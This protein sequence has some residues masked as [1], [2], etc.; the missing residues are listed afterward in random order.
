V[1]VQVLPTGPDAR[2]DA[3]AY[4]LLSAAFAAREELVLTTPYF[5][6]GE[7]MLAALA[8]AAAR[9]AQV[10]LIVPARVD[11]RL[12]EYA[13]RAFQADLIRAGV[14]VALYQGGLLHTKSITV[15]GRFCLFGSVNLDPPTCG[16]I[17]RSRWRCTTR[18]SPGPSG[19][20]KRPT[21]RSPSC[22]TW[23]LVRR[24]LPWSA[25]RRMRRA[26]SGRCCE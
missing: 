26:S 5:V 19:N 12:V 14:R 16:W 23:R 18:T 20:C 1:P 15:D 17:S 8:S 22:W 25:S 3:I 6:A 24:A 21:W 13:S 9:G 11:S 7:A 10:T 4:L 2:V